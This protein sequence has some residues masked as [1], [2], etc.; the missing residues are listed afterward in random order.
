METDW[1]SIRQKSKGEW[2][3]NVEDAVENFNRT[4]LQESCTKM[5]NEGKIVKTK[6]KSIY[7]HVSSNNYKRQPTNVIL[8]GTKHRARTIL[9]SRH[10]MLECGTNYKGTMSETCHI[11]RTIDD[12]NHRLNDCRMFTDTNQRYLR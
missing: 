8:H 4:K 1:N 5:T 2:K 11:C 12:E 6:T 9:L 3:R 10:G 7:Q